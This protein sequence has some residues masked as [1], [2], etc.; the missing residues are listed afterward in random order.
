M[1]NKYTLACQPCCL[2]Q[3]GMML[4][5]ALIAI[6]IIMT[7]IL[8][9]TGLTMKSAN[10]AGQAQYRTEAGVYAS[11]IVQTMSIR[12]D[13]SSPEALKTSLER[14]NH[15]ADGDGSG[16]ANTEVD[17]ANTEADAAN[18]ESGIAPCTFSGTATSD[19]AL[20][21]ILKA[22]RGGVRFVHGLPGAT[23]AMQQVKVDT[24][25][26][27]RVTVTLCW[28]GPNDEAARRYQM[29]AFVH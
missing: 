13:R 8:G 24:G 21:E 16:E 19:A 12:I 18:T 23:A 9:I 4:I 3:R 28:K 14:Y 20:V 6:L 15:Q 22:A 17:A 10:W 27:N 11:Q 1:L 2:Q 5:E 7:G 29:H 25:E 26:E